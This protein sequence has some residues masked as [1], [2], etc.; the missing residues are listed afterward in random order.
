MSAPEQEQIND[1]HMPLTQHLQELRKRL[2]IMLGAILVV[3]LTAWNFTPYIL[4]V[5]KQPIL[6]FTQPQ[7][8]TLTDPF[9]THMKA[10]FFTAVFLTFPVSLSQ[11]WL[12]I[13]PG[14]YKSEKMVVWPFLVLSFPLFVG[15]AAFFYFIVFPYAVDFLI[16]FDKTLVP[17]LRIGDY[18]SFTVRLLFIFG[19]VFEMPLITLLLT[20]MGIVNH[21]GMN[22]F[23]RYW[24]VVA[25]VGAA[26][27]TPPDILTQVLLGIPLMVLY[28][29]SVIVS[30]IARKKVPKEAT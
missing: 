20:R 30:W 5:I 3:F 1:T 14:L 4:E 21:K 29:I 16:N 25:F 26:I 23:R 10:A 6:S 7:F 11:I 9:F 28:E 18:L 24:I 19:L 17:S 12:F 2:T 8:D 15:G 13:A 22:K 27:L